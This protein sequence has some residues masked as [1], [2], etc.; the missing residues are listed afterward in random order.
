MASEVLAVLT[1]LALLA[2]GLMAGVFFAFSSFVMPAL[3]RLPPPQGI[4]AMQAINVRALRP[5]FL[6]AFLVGAVTC[7]LL[8]VV[9]VWRWQLPG[10]ALRVAGSA[11]Y[12]VG[13]FGVTAAF[14]VPRNEALASVR[15]DGAD[16]AAHWSRFLVSW[17][18]WNHVRTVAAL[19][20][21]ALFGLA[22]R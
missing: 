18:A 21:T 15:G 3:A 4:A 1:L 9:A 11:L 17:T 16:A 6:S 10:T 8:A 5:P 20:A 19:A 2:C 12:L 7:L 13:T 22:L 14:N